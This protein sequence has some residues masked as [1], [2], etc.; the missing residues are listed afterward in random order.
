MKSCFEKLPFTKQRVTKESIIRGPQIFR[1]S[2]SQFKILGAK[3]VT[4]CNCLSEHPK[5]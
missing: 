5:Y 3:V 1:N 2:K 4:W